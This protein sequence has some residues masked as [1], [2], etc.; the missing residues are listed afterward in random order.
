ML[1]VFF[2]RTFKKLKVHGELS[3]DMQSYGLPE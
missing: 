3:R 1:D 2:W